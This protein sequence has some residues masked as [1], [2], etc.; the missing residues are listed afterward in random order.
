M[1]VAFYSLILQY[2]G[3]FLKG[4]HAHFAVPVH[5]KKRLGYSLIHRKVITALDFLTR[6]FQIVL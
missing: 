6:K 5:K 2:W 4:H 1:M 3:G